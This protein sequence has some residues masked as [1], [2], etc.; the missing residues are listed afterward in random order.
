MEERRMKEIKKIL[1]PIDF[2][3]GSKKLLKFATYFAE[4]FGA[5]IFIVSV[6]EFQ[7]TYSYY[8]FDPLDTITTLKEDVMDYA[9]K[10]M[11]TFLEDN[12]DQLTVPVESSLLTGR[13]AEE[14]IRYAEDERVDM[15]IIGTHG[16]KGLDRMLFGSVA[17]KVIKLAP[18]P[19][20]TVNTY[21]QE[22]EGGRE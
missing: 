19:T 1:L 6:V 2:S 11:D 8:D 10:Q 18:C 4:K 15:I 9:Q 14:L 17:E 13:V 12:R 21:R 20:L 3:E 5:T 22:K 7:A 16:Y